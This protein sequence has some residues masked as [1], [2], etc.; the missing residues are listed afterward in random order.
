MRWLGG[1]VAGHTPEW[2]QL[3]PDAPVILP[4]AEPR[5]LAAD[6][7]ELLEALTADP[8]GSA[9]LRAQAA[10]ARVVGACTC[11]PSITFESKGP[12]VP[13]DAS[14]A[15]TAHGRNRAD[16]EIQVTL[17]VSRGYIHE[18]EIWGGFSDGIGRTDIPRVHTLVFD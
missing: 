16:K 17:Y 15:I 1:Y 13:S 14:F 6:E 12:P 9:E 3:A 7:R 18:L 5:G 2:G 11:C 8:R 10:S 4:L